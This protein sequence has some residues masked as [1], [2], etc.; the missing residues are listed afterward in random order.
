MGAVSKWDEISELFD[1][2]LTLPPDERDAF[3]KTAA[4][5]DETYRSVLRLVHAAELNTRM[6]ATSASSAEAVTSLETG[7]RVGAWQVD[8]LLGTGGMGEVYAVH[9][10]DGHFEQQ[11]ALKLIRSDVGWRRD[12]FNLERSILARLEH[13]NIA[14]L[15]DGGEA[16]DGRLYMVVEHV[17]GVPLDEY[18]AAQSP[19]R[20]AKLELIIQVCAAL[21]HAHSRLV[22]HRD[23]KPSNVLVN[24]EGQVRL[25]DFGVAA[26]IAQ[27][28]GSDVAAPMTLAYAAPE[29]FR[30]EPVS[31]ATDVFALGC[32]LYQLLTGQPPQRD[33]DKAVVGLEDAKLDRELVAILGQALAADPD[34]R[35]PSADALAADLQRYLGDE[36]VEAVGASRGYRISKF[37]Q[38]YKMVS[39]LTGLLVVSLVGGLAASLVFADR[40]SAEAERANIEAERARLEAE[41]AEEQT[42]AANW[43]AQFADAKSNALQQIFGANPD[44]E[45]YV[46]PQIVRNSLLRLG[47]EAIEIGEENAH[48]VSFTLLAIGQTF[49]FRNDYPAAIEM[50]EPLVK[51]GIGDETTQE[52]ARGLLARAFLTVERRDEAADILRQ[53]IAYHEEKSEFSPDHAAAAS[54][55]GIATGEDEDRLAALEVLEKAVERDIE[56][57][58]GQIT[59]FF[60]NEI[61]FHNNALGNVDVAIEAMRMG[62]E[63]RER[64][65]PLGATENDTG[66]LN[67]GK[68]LLLHRMDVDG[69]RP[70]LDEVVRINTE[71]KGESDRLGSGRLYLAEIAFLEDDAEAALELAQS[72][73]SLFET[74]S[75]GRS[76]EYPQAIRLII[77]AHAQLGN[78]AEVEAGQAALAALKEDWSDPQ[79][80]DV[81]I[82]YSEALM[83]MDR[84]DL[85]ELK[86]WQ[87]EVIALAGGREELSLL[88]RFYVR[89]MD[90]VLGDLSD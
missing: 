81:Q 79:A 86:R 60:Y 32:V 56:T 57:N 76:A 49:V 88:G 31:A 71:V 78:E 51:M 12:R 14:R 27:E 47:R 41:R 62:L 39:V 59:P 80:I 8:G 85:G 22:L 52:L 28:A 83:A 38:R 37:F 77:R 64:V 24:A 70:Y 5:D 23:V 40:A 21:S 10:A 63:A 4:N 87:E 53:T 75:G 25:I 19:D 65:D 33:S 15:I 35:Y 20:D 3:L 44:D 6:L 7:D 90:E 45:D 42:E 58:G 68:M 67:L 89:Q 46:D 17:E 54:Y 61:A 48:D 84:G 66:N 16:D 36:P 1:K 55:L 50:L 2:A 11:A 26:V 18:V 69:A 74:Y 29:Q 13:P 82:A 73:K 43:Q 34:R 9:R 30:A 72:A